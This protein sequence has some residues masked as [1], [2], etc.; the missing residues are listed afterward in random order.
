MTGVIRVTEPIPSGTIGVR[1][2]WS[3]PLGTSEE[4]LVNTGT[5]LTNL[6]LKFPLLTN[7]NCY[8]NIGY[9]AVNIF[10]KKLT[11]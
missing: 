4:N 11:L 5:F 9:D 6:F 7:H 8:I 3:L 1:T 10:L 2:C